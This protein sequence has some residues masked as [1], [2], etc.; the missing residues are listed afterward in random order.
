MSFPRP[1][2]DLEAIK[3]AL[4]GDTA[5]FAQLVLRH[6][7]GIIGFCAS[8]LPYGEGAEDAAQEVFIKAF[9]SLESFRGD[10]AF[11]TWLYRIAFN[12]C[13]NL[14]K[15]SARRRTDSLDDLPYA[16]REKAV[17]RADP[18]ERGTP[19]LD[20]LATAMA[21]LP[22]SYRALIAL[23]LQGEDYRAIAE[24]LGISLEA[25]RARLRR[26][27]LILRR[28]LRHFLPGGMS[29]NTGD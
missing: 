10:S 5:M 6:Q 1:D 28:D 19:E 15:S 25:V 8:M 23:R 12:H 13:C 3:G 4:E 27:R 2:E 24:T 16:V 20:A 29:N 21:R 17:G 11:S 22:E 14:K 26:A 7:R 9:K 18:V